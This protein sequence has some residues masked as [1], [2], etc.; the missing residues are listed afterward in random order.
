MYEINTERTSDVDGAHTTSRKAVSV[1][2]SFFVDN[3][4]TEAGPVLGV[5][6]IPDTRV[7]PTE[8]R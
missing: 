1:T 6:V 4:L 3:L 5:S 8:A 7:I 2:R